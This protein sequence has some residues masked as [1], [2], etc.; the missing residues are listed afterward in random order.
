[1]RNH[2]MKM[3]LIVVLFLAGCE[4]PPDQ[5]SSRLSWITLQPAILAPPFTT[6]LQVIVTLHDE[7]WHRLA[8]DVQMDTARTGEA[9]CFWL[10]P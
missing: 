8:C 6:G 10:V 3:I 9:K 5:P 7:P 2:W 4:Q 1:V